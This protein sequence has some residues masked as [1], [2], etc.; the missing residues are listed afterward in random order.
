MMDDSLLN[1]LIDQRYG[2]AKKGLRFC[3]VTSL[4]GIAKF[5]YLC[6]EPAP[7]ATIGF[8]ASFR[9]PVPLLRGFMISHDLVLSWILLTNLSH[10]KD[11]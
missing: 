8:I 11:E 10:E 3:L 4:D 2:C 9:L 7:I 5:S 6:A 1:R